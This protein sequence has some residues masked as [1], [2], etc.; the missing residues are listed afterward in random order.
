MGARL[1][2]R[3][4]LTSAGIAEAL[5]HPG[6][7]VDLDPERR[8]AAGLPLARIHS[9]VDDIAVRRLTFARAYVELVEIAL[10]LGGLHGKRQEISV[11]GLHR[12]V[13]PVLL[14][15][16]VGGQRYALLVVFRLLVSGGTA[17][18]RANSP[19]R[20]RDLFMTRTSLLIAAAAIVGFSGAASAQGNSEPGADRYYGNPGYQQRSTLD[21][22][23]GCEG[24]GDGPGAQGAFGFFG[25]GS[26]GAVE[27][28]PTGPT[29]QDHATAMAAVCGNKGGETQID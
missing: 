12:M 25:K 22:P 6:S 16:A 26:P 5:P 13:N 24:A 9:H 15:C 8:A 21:M 17:V 27:N 10:Y 19:P 4:A 11:A 14:A 28:K 18:S 20:F 2:I 3:H 1:R 7:F 29:G 23:E